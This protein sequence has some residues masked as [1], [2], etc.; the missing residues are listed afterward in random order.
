MTTINFTN[1][2]TREIYGLMTQTIIP[3][4]IAWILTDNG[5]QSF[6]LA[7]FS[8]FNGVSSTPPLLSVSIGHKSDGTKKDTWLNIE[9]RS[10]FIVHIPPAHLATSVT[11]TAEPLPMLPPISKYTKSA[12]WPVYRGQ[13]YSCL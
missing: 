8:F 2:P 9:S 1:K 3:R 10:H 6:N 13:S 12:G 11:K 7:P 4:P 5:D